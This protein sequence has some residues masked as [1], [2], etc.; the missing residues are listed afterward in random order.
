MF[1]FGT[2]VLISWAVMTGGI[3]MSHSPSSLDWTPVASFV[4]T[5]PDTQVIEEALRAA[6]VPFR[7]EGS[8]ATQIL[9]PHGEARRAVDALE[10]S[11]AASRIHF[12]PLD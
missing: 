3:R 11:P 7:T 8:R 10:R 5:D 1:R 6:A 9:V 4:P 2:V 12:Y